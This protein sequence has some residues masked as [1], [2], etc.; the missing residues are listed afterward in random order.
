VVIGGSYLALEFGQ[1]YARLG[2]EVVILQGGDALAER[3]DA[4]VSDAIGAIL[5]DEGIEI[6]LGA[7]ITRVER[8]A[9]GVRV[10][11]PHGAVDGTH[12]LVATGRRPNTDDLGLDTLGVK[13]DRKGM[14]EVDERLS[15]SVPGIWAAGDIRGGPAFTHTA[16]ADSKVLEDQLAGSRSGTTTGRIVPYAM[17]LDPELGRVGMTEDQARKAGHR[18]KVGRKDMSTSG[19]ARE[20]GQPTGF[21]KVVIDAE[22]DRILGASCL[23]P[24]GSDVVQVFVA[25]M[26]AG[27]TAGTMLNSVVIHPT[28]GEAAKNAVVDAMSRM[29]MLPAR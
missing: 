14:I 8:T 15:S 10:H 2:A 16:Y 19:K 6:R 27:A 21:I 29:E 22:T 7:E 25:L 11:L 20:L 24:N 9:Q 13:T 5:A 1:A 17:F 3:E 23:C 28:I 4:E 12:L 26:N 18:V